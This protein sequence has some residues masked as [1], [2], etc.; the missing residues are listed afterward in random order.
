MNCRVNFFLSVYLCFD[1]KQVKKA[2]IIF[3]SAAVGAFP[4]YFFL[5]VEDLFYRWNNPEYQ[6]E[7]TSVAEAIPDFTLFFLFFG[8]GLIV[9]IVVIEPILYFLRKS[10]NFNNRSLATLMASLTFVSGLVFGWIF[11]SMEL[12]LK[13]ILYSVGIGVLLFGFYYSMNFWINLKL[14]KEFMP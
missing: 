2:F 9:Q 5:K 8:I 6:Q 1:Q 4:V 13:D 14:K 11:G 3:L 7:L 12:G 10:G